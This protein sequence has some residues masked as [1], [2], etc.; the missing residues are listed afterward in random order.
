MK[1]Y[2]VA[3]QPQ[4][5]LGGSLEISTTTTVCKPFILRFLCVLVVFTECVN[6]CDPTKQTL[7]ITPRNTTPHHTRHIKCTVTY[8]TAQTDSHVNMNRKR[9]HMNQLMLCRVMLCTCTVHASIVLCGHPSV[10][11]DLGEN[12]YVKGICS[13]IDKFQ[14]EEAM[15]YSSLD[16]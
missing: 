13:R 7:H 10:K 15:S 4:R 5:R 8:H 9:K 2:L 16:F 1:L 12:S 6:A 3:N 14:K 11:Y